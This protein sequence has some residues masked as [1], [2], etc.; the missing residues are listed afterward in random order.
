[1]SLCRDDTWGIWGQEKAVLTFTRTLKQPYI[2]QSDDSADDSQ[3]HG[4]AAAPREYLA[5][6]EVSSVYRS[7]NLSA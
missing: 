1:M 5:S 4:Q 6:R 7:M 2:S 3:D